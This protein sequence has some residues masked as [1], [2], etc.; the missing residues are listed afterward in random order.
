MLRE[1]I[2]GG[3]VTKKDIIANSEE[4][5]KKLPNFNESETYRKRILDMA[6]RLANHGTSEDAVVKA[7][8]ESTLEDKGTQLFLYLLLRYLDF[9]T[10]KLQTNFHSHDAFKRHIS[11]IFPLLH[12]N[13]Y[14]KF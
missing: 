9:S 7:S 10:F 4:L 6:R 14:Q 2:N 13:F 5:G 12:K 3:N 1:A 8:T 11:L